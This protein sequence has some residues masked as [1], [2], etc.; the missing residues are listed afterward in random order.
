M[1]KSEK[2][3]NKEDILKVFECPYKPLLMLAIELVNLKDKEREILEY[4]Y[5]RGVTEEE[6]AYQLQISKNTVYNYKKKILDKLS[7]AWYKQEIIKQIL[8]G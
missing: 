5:V 4:I 7:K 3:L 1:L 8:E 6:T 2:K